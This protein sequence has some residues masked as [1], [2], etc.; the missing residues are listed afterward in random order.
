[1][2]RPL[3]TI[4]SNYSVA[5]CNC[6]DGY[7]PRNP[8]RP[9]AKTFLFLG[10]LDSAGFL[11]RAKFICALFI[12]S[13]P[14]FLTRPVQFSSRQKVRA[15]RRVE[16]GIRWKTYIPLG[17][18]PSQQHTH[19]RLSLPSFLPRPHFCIRILPGWRLAHFVSVSLYCPQRLRSSVSAQRRFFAATWGFLVSRRGGSALPFAQ[20]GS[21]RRLLSPA[22]CASPVANFNA[23]KNRMRRVF[24]RGEG[25]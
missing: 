20:F 15:A 1:M 10:F 5:G 12:S 11:S 21:A 16:L 17:A 24:G 3:F 4:D 8:V 13:L 14:N 6:S 7:P 18:D 22:P 23:S 19:S 25:F 9:L 2:L